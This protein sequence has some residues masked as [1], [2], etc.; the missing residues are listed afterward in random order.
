MAADRVRPD[1]T[2]GDWIRRHLGSV[3]VRLTIG[4][5]VVVG[6][7]LFA[8]SAALVTVM[9]QTL[10][11]NVAQAAEFRALEIANA[12]ETGGVTPPLDA[13]PEEQLIQVLDQSG[14]VVS[15]SANVAGR[16]ALAVL[17]PGG[18]TRLAAPIADEG[19][20]LAVAAGA[21]TPDGQRT[22]VVARSLDDVTELVGTLTRV[23]MVGLPLLLLVVGLT[24][25]RIVGRA[26]AP[27]EAIR[28]EVDV[29][30]GHRLDRRVPEPARRDE[31]SRLAETMNRMLGRLEESQARQLRFV[32]DASHELRSPVASIR[33]HSEVALA[34]P[35]RTTV[36]ELAETVL[37]EDL[38][39]QRLVEDLLLLARSDEQEVAS[40]AMVV[41]LDDLVFAEAVRLRGRVN[42]GHLR[43]GLMVDVR[44]V[45]G[46][47]VRGDSAALRRM[48]SNLGDNAVR[49]ARSR[50]TFTLYEQAAAG[51]VVLWVD[52]DGPGIPPDQRERVFERFVRL[53]DARARDGG[54]SGLGL[55][56][57][58]AVARTHG[59]TAAVSDSPGGGA[60]VEVRLPHVSD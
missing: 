56:I 3:R 26:L 49:H 1:G 36:Q 5:V 12:L 60:R 8:G 7:A 24:T 21:D 42:S 32:S 9:R 55:A 15:A 19:A 25:W 35:T 59:G 23:L 41:D 57:V 38:R 10:L 43:D 18:S 28:R 39:V 11:D 46:G 52:D 16:P 50:V 30:S 2:G 34:H 33:Q 4:A 17:R 47:R 13:F 40:D 14:E 48:I 44:G 27:V 45:S 29:I 53:D 20:F 31:I 51:E 58:E 54:G 6:V 37:T 22:V